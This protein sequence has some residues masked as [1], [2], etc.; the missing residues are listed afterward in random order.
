MDTTKQPVLMP[1]DTRIM[2]LLLGA[3]GGCLDVFSHMQFS[4]L[5]ATQTGNILL[6]VANW[7]GPTVKTAYRII[8]LIFFTCGFVLRNG[9]KVHIGVLGG[10]YH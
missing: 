5:I 8:S 7:D 6:I 1:Q 2:A 3:V 10:S 4:T 9:R